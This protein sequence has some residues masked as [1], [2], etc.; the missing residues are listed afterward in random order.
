MG[1]GE[2]QVLTP[3]NDSSNSRQDGKEHASMVSLCEWY[4]ACS[5]QIRLVTIIHA[6]SQASCGLGRQHVGWEGT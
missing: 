6:H 5:F 4:A 1:G 3:G 2:L